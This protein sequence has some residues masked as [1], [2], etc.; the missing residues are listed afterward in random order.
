MYTI[1]L[2]DKLSNKIIVH[3]G[4]V[5]NTYTFISF[6]WIHKMFYRKGKKKKY[7]LI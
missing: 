1:K 6:N 7:L 2:Q 5:L 3:Y 4:Y